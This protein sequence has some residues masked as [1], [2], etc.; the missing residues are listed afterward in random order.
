[1][2]TIRLILFAAL[3]GAITAVALIVWHHNDTFFS[4]SNGCTATVEGNSVDLD[5]T[6]S[7]NASLIA[8]I[9]MQRGLPARAVS[10]ALAAAYQESKIYNLP[11]GDLDS[12]GLFQQRPSVKVWGTAQDIRNPDHATKAFYDALMKVPNYTSLDIAVAAQT[13]QGSADGSLYAQHE[14][15]ARALASALTGYSPAAFSCIVTG[16]NELGTASQVIARLHRDYGN[17]ISPQRSVRENV[18]VDVG[19]SAAGVRMGWSV[20]QYAVAMAHGLH[21]KAVL[22]DGKKWTTGN[23]SAKGW[24]A[25]SS[26]STSTV[27]IVME[28][29][30]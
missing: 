26:A 1:M 17:A 15:E 25:D 13:V 20:A 14:T 27:S 10:I 5:T 3:V 9:G 11:Y 6:Q 30:A 4:G 2:R 22:F 16:D 18:N 24:T 21:I 28:P 23:A 7:E 29:S 19:S 8:A 12:L